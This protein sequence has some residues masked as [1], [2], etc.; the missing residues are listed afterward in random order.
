[1]PTIDYIPVKRDDNQLSEVLVPSSEIDD[2][3]DEEDTDYDEDGTDMYDRNRFLRER[4]RRYLLK[5]EL[6]AIRNQIEEDDDE[7]DIKDEW[8]VSKLSPPFD[9]IYSGYKLHLFPL[10]YIECNYTSL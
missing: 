5:Q 4:L 7:Y 2:I 9:N 1:M 10:L 6:D 8:P 3:L